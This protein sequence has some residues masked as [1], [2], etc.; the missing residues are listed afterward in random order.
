[1]WLLMERFVYSYQQMCRELWELNES[2]YREMTINTIGKTEDDREIFQA[3]IGQEKASCH[4]LLHGGMHGREYMNC[5]LLLKQMK[6]YLEKGGIEKNKEVCVHIVPM[7]NPDGCTISQQGVSG[8]RRK[9][10]RDLLE[11]CRKNRMNFSNTEHDAENFFRRW[12]ANAR[13]VDINR[14]FAAGWQGFQT[15]ERRLRGYRQPGPEGY[16]GEYPESEAETRAILRL[17]RREPLFGS[18]AYHSSGRLIYWDYG[19][20]GD[21]Y[22]RDKRLGERISKE[23]GYKLHSTVE[24]RTEGGGCS[25]YLTLKL[26]IPSVTIET[27]RHP[28]PLPKHEFPGICSENRNV[29]QAAIDALLEASPTDSE[30][31]EPTPEKYRKRKY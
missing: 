4:L 7:G 24:D 15:E 8:I 1:M 19:S 16:A 22:E 31:S 29:W 6:D 5:A 26:Q 12:K 2:F 28:C 18:I 3:M 23:T 20:V 27:G 14:N 10:L 30:A 13:G 17:A 25:D 9:E 11:E 21:I